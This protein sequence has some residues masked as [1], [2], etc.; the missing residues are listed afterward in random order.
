MVSLVGGALAIPLSFWCTRL[1]ASRQFADLP[2]VRIA[3]EPVTLAFAFGCAVLTGVIFGA[4]PAWLAS[5]ADINDVL[6]QNPQSMTAR[7]VDRSASDRA[8]RGRDR[9]RADHRWPARCRSS[10]GCSG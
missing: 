6:K 10:A 7:A 2:G 3:L 4:V 8:D 5:R 9:V 1:I